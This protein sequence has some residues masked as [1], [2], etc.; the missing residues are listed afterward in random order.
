MGNGVVYRADHGIICV[1]KSIFKDENLTNEDKGILAT[2]IYL[3]DD[4]NN[5][6]EVSEL[7]S[8]TGLSIS[9]LTK[10]FEMLDKYDYGKIICAQ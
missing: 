10:Y 1:P 3:F 6:V 7:E 9:E 4:E 2:I 5:A 8:S